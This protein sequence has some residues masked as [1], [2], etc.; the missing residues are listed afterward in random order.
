[1]VGIICCTDATTNPKHIESGKLTDGFMIGGIKKSTLKKKYLPTMLQTRE[2]QELRSLSTAPPITQSGATVSGVS[3][4]ENNSH[5]QKS[6]SHGHGRISE[7]LTSGPIPKA[8]ILNEDM[9]KI[10]QAEIVILTEEKKFGALSK[11]PHGRVMPILQAM[12]SHAS[13]QL[14]K[15]NQ[16]PLTEQSLSSADYAPH[17]HK[18]DVGIADQ[19]WTPDFSNDNKAQMDH[20]AIGSSDLFSSTLGKDFKY[21]EQL[22]D[23]LLAT[24]RGAGKSGGALAPLQ[25]KGASTRNRRPLK[26][27]LAGEMEF[28]RIRKIRTLS[29]KM[30]EI[31]ALKA[32]IEDERRR[33]STSAAT[34]AAASSR[35]LTST[36]L[37]QLTA[38][39]SDWQQQQQ[40]QASSP[41]QK[42]DTGSSSEEHR[43]YLIKR[44][45][46]NHTF[47]EAKDKI[48]PTAA[49][50]VAVEDSKNSD[51]ESSVKKARRT[52]M[53]DRIASGDLKSRTVNEEEEKEKEELSSTSKRKM[54]AE[55]KANI[56][57]ARRRSVADIGGG[58][59]STKSMRKSM[60]EGGLVGKMRKKSVENDS[61]GD[62]AVSVL[63]Q[64]LDQEA[65][66]LHRQV[67]H[68]EM[69]NVKTL[70]VKEAERASKNKEL[71]RD[72][73]RK[74]RLLTKVEGVRVGPPQQD[75]ANMYDYYAIRLQA[76]I[77]GWLARCWI[78]WF[79]KM[80][81]K[82]AIKLQSTIRGWLG[83]LRV[84]RIRTRD[85]A[86]T[87][88][89]KNFRGWLTRVSGC[90]DSSS[91]SSSS[92][93][94]LCE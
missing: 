78:K 65:L 35:G 20:A 94:M 5:S 57:E 75:D 61:G 10:R 25:S 13:L 77:R 85:R 89:Q 21:S 1:M 33:I 81:T 19:P 30:Q 40:Q 86:A 48:K 66:Q 16:R 63:V 4:Q 36:E 51:D 55:D 24:T 23:S 91:S 80:S 71:S 68:Y 70:A 64:K 28:Q 12:T 58:G 90:H 43:R 93:P 22:D 34:A 59:A 53:I 37:V 82:A 79:K 26:T 32:E 62:G 44:N 7:V 42:D 18:S 76:T 72:I 14:R 15:D 88:I 46:S 60:S 2:D 6:S 92:S 9:A 38:G 45:I 27:T 84:R 39:A 50:A 54:V 73:E 87:L 56:K 74:R 11:D 3:T 29:E 49:V 67:H 47:G 8:F 83:R 31:S 17:A 69:E 41:P 52:S